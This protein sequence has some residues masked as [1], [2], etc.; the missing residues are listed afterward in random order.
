MFCQLLGELFGTA[1]TFGGGRSSADTVANPVAGGRSTRRL[2]WSGWLLR[3]GF[4]DCGTI[5][6]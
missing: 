3:F 1:L 4:V 5:C 6:G 2:D